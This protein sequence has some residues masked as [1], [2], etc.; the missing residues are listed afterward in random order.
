MKLVL[1]KVVSC[2]FICLSCTSSRPI[3]G[4]KCLPIIDS[5]KIFILT[6]ESALNVQ[7]IIKDKERNL[8]LDKW[9][10]SLPY[11]NLTCLLSDEDPALKLIGFQYA[12]VK[13]KDSLLKDY[14]FLLTDT[15]T[16]QVFYKNGKVG[17]KLKF[18]ELLSMLLEKLK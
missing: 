18:G 1:I 3:S 12:A 14:S 11:Q 4:N 5:A 2:I 15:T 7:P 9:L 16:V 13:A 8:R 6:D 10:Q 17:S